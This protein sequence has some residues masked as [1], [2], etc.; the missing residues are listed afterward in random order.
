M[1]EAQHIQPYTGRECPYLADKF[2]NKCGW[3]KPDQREWRAVP[4]AAENYRWFV[5]YP[6]LVLFGHL[7]RWAGYMRPEEVTEQEFCR[8]ATLEGFGT[9]VAN[10]TVRSFQS[11]AGTRGWAEPTELTAVNSPE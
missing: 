1:S 10:M 7:F 5:Q 3:S 4:P 2:C 8:I 9:A 6:R 11:F